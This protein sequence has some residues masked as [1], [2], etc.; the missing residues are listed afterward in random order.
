MIIG[1]IF[2]DASAV[3]KYLFLFHTKNPTAVTEGFW[4]LFINI[5]SFLL[6]L[7]SQGTFKMFMLNPNLYLYLGNLGNLSISGKVL[8]L[9]VGAFM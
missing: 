7:L 2:L 3:V 5:W 8:V 1:L 9:N 4:I 6:A